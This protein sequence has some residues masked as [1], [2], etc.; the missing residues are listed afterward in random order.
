MPAF[1]NIYPN[2]ITWSSNYQNRKWS[3]C[4][5]THTSGKKHKK[6]SSNSDYDNILRDSESIFILPRRDLICLVRKGNIRTKSWNQAKIQMGCIHQNDSRTLNMVEIHMEVLNSLRSLSLKMPKG[7]WRRAPSPPAH[8]PTNLVAAPAAGAERLNG[9]AV[10][11]PN[12]FLQ[13]HWTQLVSSIQNFTA[14]DHSFH[15]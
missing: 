4:S 12:L 9:G 3:S 11:E 5:R 10:Q 7:R 6:G 1:F 2:A 13:S 15:A 8:H 14:A